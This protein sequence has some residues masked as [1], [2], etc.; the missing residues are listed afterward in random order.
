M[1]PKSSLQ[2]LE[3]VS[4]ELVEFEEVARV[5]SIAERSSKRRSVQFGEHL[6]DDLR[7]LVS[8][9]RLAAFRFRD[10]SGERLD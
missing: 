9:Q 4:L 5:Y 3:G 10:L 6:T 2:V 1:G 7:G 8:R